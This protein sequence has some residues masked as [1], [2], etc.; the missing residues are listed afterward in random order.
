MKPITTLLY[1][2]TC[3]LA[4]LLPTAACAALNGHYHGN[5]DGKAVSA[6][7]EDQASGVSGTLTIG[8]TQYILQ[9]EKSGADYQGTLINLS[10]GYGASLRIQEQG[11][12][13]KLD[14]KAEG[15]PAQQ[16]E[17]QPD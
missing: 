8:E 5:L 17:L 11:E 3:S 15:K 1:A 2:L 9:V 10:K 6:T 14:I 4:L 12:T 7:F 16:L 13:L